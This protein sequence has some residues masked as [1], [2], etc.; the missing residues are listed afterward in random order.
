MKRKIKYL[1]LATL[2]LTL[3]LASGCLGTGVGSENFDIGKL[4]KSPF[5][6]GVIIIVLIVLWKRGKK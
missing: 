2:L 6:I 5:G 1:L 4:L 3:T